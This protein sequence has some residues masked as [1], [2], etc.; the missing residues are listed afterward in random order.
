MK[1]LLLPVA[2][3]AVVVA[4]VVVVAA[5]AAWLA[6]WLAARSGWRLVHPI[7]TV[8]SGSAL[9]GIDDGAV[10]RL[11]PGR[12]AWRVDAIRPLAGEIALS[13][14]HPAVD[15][16]V[17]IVATARGARI[18]AGAARAPAALLAAAG[19]PFNTL[20]PGGR[21]AVTWTEWRVAAGALDGQAELD[22]DDAQSAL[23]PV[24]PLGS[25]RVRI[26][27][28]GPRADARLT[29]TRGPLLLQGEGTLDGR[30]F[31]FR[32]TADAA[33][34][35]RDRLDGLLGTLGRRAGDKVQLDWEWAR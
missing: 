14:T 26:E 15:N 13:L 18:A 29:T 28:R 22:W 8:W 27:S 10:T 2:L 32:G 6:D 20:Q 11:L 30:R 17:V 21:L 19:T 23:A 9:V 35:W 4:A 33:A 16:P 25:Y 31:R 7:G 12:L 5:P 24:V 1:T 34:D 3:V